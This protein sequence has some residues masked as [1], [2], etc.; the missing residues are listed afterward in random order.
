MDA[1]P[2][3]PQQQGDQIK[4]YVD[5]RHDDPHSVT[6]RKKLSIRGLKISNYIY[7]YPLFVETNVAL[8]IYFYIYLRSITTSQSMV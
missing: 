8:F 6:P 5:Y 7:S 1:R 3:Q 2:Q 4:S